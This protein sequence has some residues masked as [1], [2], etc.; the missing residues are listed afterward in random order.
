MPQDIARCLEFI[1]EAER[2][3][4]HA[5]GLALFAFFDAFNF[6]SYQE[7]TSFLIENMTRDQDYFFAENGQCILTIRGFKKIAI[8]N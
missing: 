5:M 8:Q 7:A 2:S 4:Y 3:G 1:E 6:N